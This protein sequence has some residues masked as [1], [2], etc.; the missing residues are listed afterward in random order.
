MLNWRSELDPTV[1]EENGGMDPPPNTSCVR[2][3]EI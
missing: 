1:S 2:Y 3:N